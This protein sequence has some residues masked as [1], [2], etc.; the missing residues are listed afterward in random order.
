MEPEREPGLAYITCK[1]I[2][3]LIAFLVRLII[4][5]LSLSCSDSEYV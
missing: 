5:S 2:G 1:D 4:S 3:S